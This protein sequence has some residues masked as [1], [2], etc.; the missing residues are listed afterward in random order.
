M[1]HQSVY[2]HPSSII[3]PKAKVG[4]GVKIGPFCIVGAEVELGD[5]VELK[6]HVVI[7]TIAHIGEGTQIF[8]FVSIHIPQDKKFKGERSFVK[9]GKNTIIREYVTIQPGTA[10]DRMCTVVG[11][12]CLLMASGHIAHDCVVGNHVIMA[13]NA[14]LA[15]HVT[16]GDYAIIGG[17]AAIHQFVTIGHHAIIGGMSG[18]ESDVIPYGNVKGDRAY[19][20]GLNIIGMKRHGFSRDE[21]DQLREVYDRLFS[22]EGTLVERLKDLAL[23]YTDNTKV[24]SLI[25][26]L[27]R[28]NVRSVLMPRG[29]ARINF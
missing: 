28:E 22:Q 27:A 20:N 25:D 11:D 23:E 17:L 3:D 1:V 15:G 10:G 14:T 2:I 29:S 13:N 4:Q 21:I 6:S 9:I 19:L 16:I 26:F 18:V 24:M 8:P 5:G 12:E 7:D